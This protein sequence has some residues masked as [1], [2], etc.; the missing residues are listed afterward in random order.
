MTLRL[1]R[2]V[3]LAALSLTAFACSPPSDPEEHRL[4]AL[5]HLQE[6]DGTA[7]L[8]E[9]QR[10]MAL[11][12]AAGDLHLLAARAHLVE[13]RGDLAEEALDQ[14]LTLGVAPQLTL[15]P[16]ARA[17]L[18]QDEH[19]SLAALHVPD[20]APPSIRLGVRHVKL[21]AE[22]AQADPERLSDQLTRRYL[23]FFEDVAE[24]D[25]DLAWPL[26]R[27]PHLRVEAERA[28]QHH[29]CQQ[30]F[31]EIHSWRPAPIN[32]E[33]RVLRVGPTR[34]YR[35]PAAAA[36]AARDGDVIEIDAGLYE[37]G[38]ALWPQSGILLRGV[39]GRPAITAAGKGIARRD[40]WLFTGDDV[41]VENVAISGARSPYGNGAGIRHIGSGLTLRHV[42]L[43]DNENGV[44]TGNNRPDSRIVIEHSEFADNG[45]G[46]GWAHNLYIG[47]AA[48]LQLRFSYSH[49]A[50][51][52]HQ[53]K[54]LARENLIAYNRLSDGPMGASGY[55]V[56]LSE[57]GSA[58][59]I[60]NQLYHGQ[61]SVNRG[62]ISFGAESLRHE[63]NV[64]SVASNSIYNR[65]PEAILVRNPS[66][67][68]VILVNNLIGGAAPTLCQDNCRSRNNLAN[69]AH[70]MRDPGNHDF[71][72]T[73][74]APAVDAAA[75]GPVPEFEY[76][77]PVSYRT[78][79]IVWRPDV[80]AHER[81][82][83]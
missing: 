27:E 82:G 68:A 62:M 53:L 54:S 18:L 21:Q 64:L 77:H 75:P 57:G 59:I 41:E 40:V 76:H 42:L 67:A 44:L 73:A 26:E 65:H 63:A 55:L 19:E 32:A 61:R 10:A 15:V 51:G 14:A 37:G 13:G 72:L 48:R 8:D 79:D 34:S 38:V 16:R 83:L 39:G 17:L 56:D 11:D 23:A 24:H 43:A 5:A 33:R 20:D 22:A 28:W 70:G 66:G 30:Q 71:H 52:G 4:R 35:S 74:A 2:T 7:A 50:N 36:E 80:G 69:G 60:G 81:C 31:A 45:D 47:R 3:T 49:G 6:A 29:V 78:R 9:L 25:V 12:P 1:L 46:D 58:T